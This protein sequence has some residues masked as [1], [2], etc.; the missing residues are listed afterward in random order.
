MYSFMF[1]FKVDCVYIYLFAAF[2]TM[3]SVGHDNTVE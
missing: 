1:I 3:L 2:L